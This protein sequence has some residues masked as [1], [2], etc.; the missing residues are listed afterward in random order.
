MRSLIQKTIRHARAVAWMGTLLAFVGAYFSV[1]LY[2]NLRTDIEE[3][4]PSSARSVV[5]LNEVTS[6]LEAVD[7]IVLLAFSEQ[8]VQSKKFILD[9]AQRLSQVPKQTISQ[10]EYRIDRELQFFKDRRPLFIDLPDLIQLKNY[11]RDRIHYEKELYNPLNIF[12]GKEIPEP[13]LDYEAMRKKYENRV[14]GYDHFPGGF[15]ATADEKIRA[16][17]LYMPGKG[18]NKALK[19]KAELEKA[20]AELNPKSYAADLEVKFT[21]NGQN[22]IEES[23]ALVEDLEVSTVIV[24]VVVTLAMLAFYRSMG[25]TLAL[26]VSLL[27]GT[28][29]T[30]GIS[31]FVVGYLNANTAFLA[32]IVIGNGINFGI[33]FLARYLE[34]RRNGSS[35]PLAVETALISTAPSTGTAALAAGLSYGSLM[36]TGFRGFS[37]F[38]IIGLLGMICCWISACTLLPAY[39]TL[40]DRKL[41]PGWYYPKHPSPVISGLLARFVERLPKTIWTL[42]LIFLAISLFLVKNSKLDLIE[43]DMNKLRDKRSMTTGS[44]ALYHYI[45]D[46][47]QHSFSPIVVLPK[48]R[49]HTQLIAD[50]FKQ[51]RDRPGS[52]SK[53]TTVQ[54]LEDFVPSQQPEKIKVLQEIRRLLPVRLINLLPQAEKTLVM[55]LLNPKSFVEFREKDLPPLILGKFRETDGSLGKI[56]LVDKK[57]EKGSDDAN[58]I[59][60]FVRTTR[61]VAD[62]VAPHTPVAGDLAITYDMFQSITQDGPKATLFAF[63]AVLALVVV[64][65]RS[66]KTILLVLVAL[67]F[68]VIW[69]AGIIIG[70]H[71]KINF[72]NFI[73]LPITFGIGLDYGVNIFQRY[74]IEGPG[75][76]LSVIRNTGGAVLLSSLTTIIGYGSLLIAGNQAF[77]SFGLLAVL[78]EITCI[79]GAIIAL[80]AFLCFLEERKKATRKKLVLVN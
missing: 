60:E 47:F 41:K 9:L 39:L 1:L 24:M 49:E 31:Y 62:S 22:M 12:R 25:A 72:L 37:Q 30:F 18:L 11:I 19:L 17:I 46:I 79:I 68:G 75:K 3:L 52:Q 57:I 26:V 73:A 78:G 38:G 71:V 55:E 66:L 23:A 63:L 32:S 33:I 13:K 42:S 69:L 40:L 34:E 45:D 77:V 65:F 8:P 7:N 4:L 53:I 50:R 16:M 64:L 5:D 74:K 80:P 61:K 48:K 15:Y 51:E 70:F 2:M 44:G 59:A 29:W 76:I 6:R 56:V 43:T 10:V 54:T 28:F 58:T 14:A 21:G 67:G 20:V 36:L 27:M 35:H